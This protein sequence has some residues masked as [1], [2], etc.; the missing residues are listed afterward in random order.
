MPS[1]HSNPPPQ[2]YEIPPPS[3]KAAAKASTLTVYIVSAT[4]MADLAKV[5]GTDAPPQ[6]TELARCF[7]RGHAELFMGALHESWMRPSIEER[8]E[9]VE[10]QHVAHGGTVGK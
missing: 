1:S 10:S 6:R 4:T 9:T 5:R 8:T 3:S 7:A 2:T